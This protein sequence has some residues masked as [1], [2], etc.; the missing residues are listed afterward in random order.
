MN[1]HSKIDSPN[2]SYH[3]PIHSSAVQ[4]GLFLPKS[5]ITRNIIISE[6][7]SAKPSTRQKPQ[8]WGRVTALNTVQTKQQQ[9]IAANLFVYSQLNKSLIQVIWCNIP[10]KKLS[11]IKL[12]SLY[13][14]PKIPKIRFGK[15]QATL[16]PNGT[17]QIS[18]S[19]HFINFKHQNS[20]KIKNQNKL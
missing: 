13:I 7:D 12:L 17:Q 20:N 2:L 19:N 1:F 10:H 16:R 9:A 8:N 3:K 4:S 15:D 11:N 6:K 5:N 18:S 14:Q